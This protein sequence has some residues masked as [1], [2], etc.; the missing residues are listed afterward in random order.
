MFQFLGQ[1]KLWSGRACTWARSGRQRLETAHH[2]AARCIAAIT[3]GLSVESVSVLPA[4]GPAGTA[5]GAHL[6]QAIFSA[7][8]NPDGQVA[9]LKIDIV[10]A[11]AGP[12]ARMKLRPRKR[13]EWGDNFKLAQ[14]WASWAAF[15]ASGMSI[16]ELDADG[17]IELSDEQQLFADQLLEQCEQRA[18]QIVEE[19]W[20]EITTL[21]EALLDRT[22]L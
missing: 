7:D 19:R 4:D 15:L 16:A 6:D 1:K 17:K 20:A 3:H 2:K 18:H 5:G 13:K 8:H 14:A 12:A 22:V 11:L 9:A 21:A 10:V